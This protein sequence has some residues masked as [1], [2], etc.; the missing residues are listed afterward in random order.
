MVAGFG[1]L[2]SLVFA[3]IIITAHR[4]YY[5][6]IMQANAMTQVARAAALFPSLGQ[7]AV[8]D[9]AAANTLLRN[10]PFDEETGVYVVDTDGRVLASSGQAK[11]FWSNW[12]VDV[13][14]L[15]KLLQTRQYGQLVGDDPD[16]I[17]ER[18][19]FAVAPLELT[20]G[21]SG[22]LYVQLRAAQAHSTEIFAA[23]GNAIKAALWI[24]L[25]VAIV[26]IALTISLLGMLTQPLRKL[27][28]VIDTIEHDGLLAPSAVMAF[29][30]ANGGDEISR[31]STAFQDM[32][33]RIGR[34]M[35]QLAHTDSLRRELVASVSHDLRSPL[36][37]LI[38]N[39]E[40]IKLKSAALTKTEQHC[41]IDIAL[42]NARQIDRLSSSLFELAVLDSAEFKVS[43]EP[44]AIA[45]LID[46]ITLRFKH[47]AAESAIQLVVEQQ[48]NLPRL[49]ADAALI[50][51]MIANLLDN[52]LRYTPKNGVITLSLTHINNGVQIK[53]A[54]TGIGIA[55][56]DIAHIFDRFYQGNTA[57]DG[58]GH[59][60]LG[61]AI[62]K[63]IVELHEATI[64][65][66]NNAT[67]G[68]CFEINFGLR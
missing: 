32:L 28:S 6:E 63:R 58:H 19:L 3:A 65:V 23:T 43:R 2:L 50:E 30:A 48:D 18:C 11:D 45:E 26:G 16:L 25:M 54:D 44:M 64:T 49:R 38:G 62:V 24:G 47:R 35:K 17:G 8:T 36:T 10:F 46:D 55:A 9:Q 56:A 14:P 34:Q 33:E 68:C 57:R 61:L 39:L 67:V 53:I 5:T 21:K 29:P 37:S 40:T 7:L 27:T 59:A 31:L 12:R 52:A 20:P 66:K 4:S 42:N 15:Q 51:R 1:F 41:L 13:A 22:Y 60:G